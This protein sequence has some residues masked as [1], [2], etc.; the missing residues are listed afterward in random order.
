MDLAT[1]VNAP[2]PIELA[3]GVY[4]CSALT[5]REWGPVQSWIKANVPG[6]MRVL[7]SEDLVGLNEADKRALF[8][9]AFA[10]QRNWPP[11]VGSAEWFRAL[12]LPGGHAEFLFVALSKHQ[13]TFTRE[14]AAAL[15]AKLSLV[16]VMPVVTAC[17]GLGPDDLKA[18]GASPNAPPETA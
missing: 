13:P 6:P 7:S 15:D 18:P 16:D 8:E 1:F 10:A 9:Q 14:Q 4:Q 11:R 12:D 17:L 2:V 3:G 5:L